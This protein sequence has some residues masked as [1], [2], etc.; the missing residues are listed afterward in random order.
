MMYHTNI[1]ICGRTL[2]KIMKLSFSGHNIF[3]GVGSFW[4][5]LSW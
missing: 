3:H 5:R 4:I 2:H 1:L